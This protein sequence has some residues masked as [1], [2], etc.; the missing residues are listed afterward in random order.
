MLRRGHLEHIQQSEQRACV[1]AVKH[2]ADICN[3]RYIL[4][5]SRKRSQGLK[6]PKG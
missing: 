4:H 6:I 5:N 1:I 3:I 2:D